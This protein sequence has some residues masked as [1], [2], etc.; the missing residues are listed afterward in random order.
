MFK[1]NN[2]IH[3]MHKYKGEKY[4]KGSSLFIEKF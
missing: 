2:F 1:N 4:I 3:K